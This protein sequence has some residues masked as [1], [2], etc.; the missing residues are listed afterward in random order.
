VY[1]ANSTIN[2][3]F[4][5]DSFRRD[6][7]MLF[8][9]TVLARGILVLA[10]PLLA[11]FFNP[12]DV[13]NWQLFVSSATVLATI[14]CWRYEVA[15]P[16][17]AD[18]QKS[19][20]LVA[21]CLLLAAATSALLILPIFLCR[22]QFVALVGAQA[23]EPFLWC[24]PL[25]TLLFGCEQASTFWLTRVGDFRGVGAARVVKSTLMVAVPLLAAMAFDVG[26]GGLVAGT[27]LGQL[28]AT[29]YLV[30]E[31]RSS[32]D[33]WRLGRDKL[34]SYLAVMF[35]YRNYPL[36]VAP[37]TFVGQF[38]K[39]LVYFLLAAFAGASTVG[40]FAMAMQLTYVPVTFVTAALNQ[41]FYRRAAQ[42]DVRK[43]E[44]L[45]LKVLEL[46]V[47]LA[48]PLFVLFV[49]HGNYVLHFALDP[50][51]NEAVGFVQWLAA[52]S[53]M[54]FFTAWLD[55]LLDTLGRQRLAV[56]MQFTYDAV[57]I[58][59]LLVLLATGQ[60]TLA[61]VASYCLVTSLYNFVWLVVAFRVARFS[62]VGLWRQTVLAS[63]LAGVLL[64]A[65]E[66]IV[67]LFDHP[68]ALCFEVLIAIAVQAA[69]MR[70]IRGY[71][72]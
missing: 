71:R 63:A 33:I 67:R 54:L 62:L 31:D 32:A 25:F 42:N 36:Y 5:Q 37:Y 61:A 55:R 46:Q 69:A 65:H 59:L 30:H 39:R 38:S 64:I 27:M 60:S 16:L 14:I 18:E 47:I 12:A 57:S 15:I 56:A 35:E 52:P 58:G 13:G 68:A 8:T 20:D 44:S 3:W 19:R 41:A 28:A 53:L 9:S 43:L 11:R 1:A 23:I 50:S 10:M 6:A 24:I 21:V 72:T 29:A 40:Y 51:W 17:P 70:F 45:I 4:A 7:T 66:I 2:R 48:V 22:D 34:Q 49:L 26:F